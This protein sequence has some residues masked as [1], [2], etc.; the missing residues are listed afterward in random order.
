MTAIVTESMGWTIGVMAAANLFL[1]A[2]LYLVSRLP[3]VARSIRENVALWD[4]A[5]ITLLLVQIV[6]SFA[7]IGLAIVL[8]TRKR[9]FL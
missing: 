4:D 9:D 7:F 2:Y 5:T 3:S 8:Q 6:L 1:Q